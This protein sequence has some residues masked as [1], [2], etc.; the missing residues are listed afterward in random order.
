MSRKGLARAAILLLDAI[1]GSAPE[2]ANVAER[3]PELLARFDALANRFR[4]ESANLPYWLKRT[5]K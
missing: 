3:C 5:V 2:A 1:D 4:I